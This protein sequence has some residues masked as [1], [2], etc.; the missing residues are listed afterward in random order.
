M[1]GQTVDL[2][3]NVK[4]VTKNHY[5]V[6]T[7]NIIPGFSHGSDFIHVFSLK[8]GSIAVLLA[9]PAHSSAL[10]LDTFT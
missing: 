2:E 10:K 5:T 8:R 3:K 1:N 4:G 6:N 7:F 9:R